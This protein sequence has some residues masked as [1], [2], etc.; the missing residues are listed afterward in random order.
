MK[1]STFFRQAPIWI[2]VGAMIVYAVFWSWFTIGRAANYT[3]GWYDLGIM[4]QT[5]WRAGHG[6][7]FSFTNP[8]MGANGQH[9]LETVRTA[10]H[11]DYIL[12]LLGPLSWVGTTWK[13][14]L[15]L[16]AVVVALGA[17]FI[18]RLGR[19]FLDS[20]WW[21][22]GLGLVYL[23]YAP[24]QFA[25]IFEFHAVTLAIL[26]ILAAADAIVGKRPRLAWVWVAL[27]LIM[28][29]QVGVT[30]GL[31][32]GWLWWRQHQRR[33]AILMAAV[34]W[35]YAIVQL[36]VIIPASRP[37]LPASFVSG[38]FYSAEEGSLAMVKRLWPPQA[39]WNRLV[40]AQ[41]R[42]DL[43]QL[44]VPLGGVIPLL[45][46]VTYFMMPEALVYW[47]SDSPNQ[48]TLYLHYQALFIPCLFLGLLFGLHWIRRR[49]GRWWW[50]WASWASIFLI[51]AGSVWMLRVASPLPWSPM[52]RWPLVAWKER[53]SPDVQAALAL[54]PKDASVAVTQNLGPQASERPR[55]TLLPTG[56]GTERFLLILQRSFDPA[57]RS[58]DKR[59]AE[60]TMLEQ[61]LAWVEAQPASFTVRYH[62]DRVWLIERIGTPTLPEPT[63]PDNLLGR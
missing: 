59:Y 60:R 38:K 5:V 49:F 23:L 33:Q 3:A 1:R 31:M 25:V 22:C 30:L 15:A 13:N 42:S 35:I 62:V 48:Q 17:W 11:T 32:T 21:G 61:L 46:P 36:V 2:V 58:N 9:G 6:Y 14:L 34:C 16:Q 47:L 8:E 50:P 39:A 41:H 26:C 27:A 56:A 4:S 37:N 7:G 54:L 29:E 45:S 53:Q 43:T 44:F 12:W 57:V 28:K 18:F 52:T 19:R 20:A 63:W 24:L 40:T 10:I 51:V 55:V